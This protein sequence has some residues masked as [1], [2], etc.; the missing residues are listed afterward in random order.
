MTAKKITNNLKEIK[1]TVIGVLVWIITGAYF[2]T[3]YFSD[4]ELWVPEHY[5]VT[6]G[7]IGGLLLLL[8]PDRFIEFLFGW[9]N[10]TK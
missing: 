6:V 10:K 7:F 1:T 9:L 4:R 2:F 5:E 8:A 3:P